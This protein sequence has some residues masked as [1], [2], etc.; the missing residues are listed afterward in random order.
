MRISKTFYISSLVMASLVSCK[1]IHRI[2]VPA[3][4]SNAIELPSKKAALTEGQRQ[5]WG[6]A[7]I[8]NDTIPGMSIAKAYEFLKGKKSTEIIVAVNDS[9]VDLGHEDLENVL[10]TNPKEIPGNGIDDDKNK[11]VDD[12]HG[13]N[14]LGEIYDENLEITR[15]IKEKSKKFDGKTAA[16]ISKKD[17]K[18]YDEYI[19]LK[20]I[21]DKKLGE[22]SESKNQFNFYYSLYNGAHQAMVKQTGKETYNLEDV[23][24][25]V[26]S[27]EGLIKQKEMTIR[28]LKGGTSYAE[29]MKQ[30]QGGIDYYTSQVNAHYNLDFNP[31]KELNND[32][33]NLKTKVYGDGNPMIR[34]A[35]EIHGTHVAGIILA[36][37]GNGKGV[38]GVA[39]NVK[40]MSVRCVPN[41]DEY[42]KDVAL[43]FKYAV[44]NGAKVIN[45]S[46]GKAYSPHADWVH[47]AIKYAEKHDVLIVNAAGNDAANID[48]EASFPNDAPDLSKEISDNM[49]TIGAMGSSYDKNMLAT[50][51]NYG[52]K[53]VD[54]FAPGVKIY[55]PVPN[56][57]YKYLSGTS[58]ASPSTAGVAAMIR[59]YYPELS[60]KQVKYILMN[61]GVEINFKLIKPGTKDEM[62]N[63][64][65]LCVSGRIVNAY[66][67]VKMAEAMV[68][69]K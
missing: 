32:E 24:A 46:F 53:N 30:V 69:K 50:F 36:E 45:T 19:K 27:D 25:I 16:D 21:F 61:S 22:A 23:E 12:I 13:W 17:K 37:N 15:I 43:G 54:I 60:A 7:D 47:D 55:A 56:G 34:Q 41:G 4:V 62:V 35:D 39:T 11:Y 8:S 65:D 3:A 26:T 66:N 52:K 20:E 9:G 64:S 2:A 1:S 49:I 63:L 44:D 38:D 29:Q 6:H 33:N 67:A 48:I 14:F 57:A 28:L 68:S 5:T 51:S 58:M 42:D 18:E 31:R 40:L 10:W 59:S